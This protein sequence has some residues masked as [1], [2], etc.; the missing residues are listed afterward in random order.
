MNRM[1]KPT[2]LLK[3]CQCGC[4]EKFTAR[5]SYRV[6]DENGK[7][8]HPDY[9]RG[10][11]P[12]CRKTQTGK[13]PPWNAGLKKPDHPSMTR[14]GFQPGHAA[15]HD[16][17]SVNA[18]LRNDPEVKRRWLKSKKGQRAWN[19]GLTKKQYPNGIASGKDHGNWLG[20]RN[21]IRDTAVFADFRRSILKRDNWTCTEC[22]DR[23]RKGRGSRIVLHVDH[24][25][26]LCVAPDRALDPANAR[27]L[28]FKCHKLT[29]TYGP[30]VRHYIR[31]RLKT[32][33]APP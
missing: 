12:N 13:A 19:T 32:K 20:G 25:E 27:T 26:P 5:L 22:G 2:Y 8:T 3:I 4:G 33:A 1:S 24:I 18:L 28:C 16:W 29:E 10:H 17:S 9:K 21:G 23:N 7:P 11:H 31:K 6:R 30:K 15:F 14:M